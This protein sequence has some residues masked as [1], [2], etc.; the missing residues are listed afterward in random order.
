MKKKG[1]VGDPFHCDTD[2]D[3]EFFP[4]KSFARFCLMVPP[5]VPLELTNS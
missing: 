2:T 1:S 5:D 3:L 4:I